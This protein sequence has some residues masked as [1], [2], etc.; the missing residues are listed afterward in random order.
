MTT[1]YSI[2]KKIDIFHNIEKLLCEIILQILFYLIFF[3]IVIFRKIITT[4]YNVFY[5]SCITKISNSELRNVTIYL[6]RFLLISSLWLD[7]SPASFGYHL[8]DIWHELGHFTWLDKWRAYDATT[9]F[10]KSWE[11]VIRFKNWR[12]RDWVRC[13]RTKSRKIKQQRGSCVPRYLP[14]KS[15]NFSNMNN[16]IERWIKC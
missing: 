15:T 13:S 9:R 14:Y 4:Y 11:D 5:S 10:A 7:T 6:P 3:I 1:I 2:G 16:Y 12:M 8:A